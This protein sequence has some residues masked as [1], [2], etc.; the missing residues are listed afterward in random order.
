MSE[1]LLMRHKSPALR[2]YVQRTACLLH[3]TDHGLELIRGKPCAN[4][5]HSFALFNRSAQ[6]QQISE[7]ESDGLRQSFKAKVYHGARRAHG[8]DRK[9]LPHECLVFDPQQSMVLREA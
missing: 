6:E 5:Q 7:G 2:N 9:L 3:G 8:P 1:D 4:S